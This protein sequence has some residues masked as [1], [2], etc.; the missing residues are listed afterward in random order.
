MA[1][2][3]SQLNSLAGR[4]QQAMQG[5]SLQFG[6]AERARNAT[7]A[8]RGMLHS[9]VRDTEM[10]RAFAPLEAQRR[11]I[12]NTMAYGDDVAEKDWGTQALQLQAAIEQL[13]AAAKNAEIEERIRAEQAGLQHR[14]ALGG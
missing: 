14:L 2:P 12:Q 8:Q 4:Y 13:K 9:G 5:N 1:E 10:Q 6:D 11:E 7:D 3:E